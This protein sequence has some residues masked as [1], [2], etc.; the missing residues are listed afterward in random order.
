MP[1]EQPDLATPGIE[2]SPVTITEAELQKPVAAKLLYKQVSELIVEKQKLILKL[3][4][5]QTRREQ[6]GLQ[7]SQADA[8]RQ[9][10]EEKISALSDRNSISQLIWGAM[11]IAIGL[12]IDFSKSGN[13]AAAL[14]L[15]ALIIFLGIAVYLTNLVKK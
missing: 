6:I 5:E 9:V 10:L 4:V 7:L 13:W 14:L 11:A 1:S 2:V 3:E 12:A 8:R 15:I